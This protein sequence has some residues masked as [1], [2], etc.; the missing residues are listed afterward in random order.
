[1]QSDTLAYGFA[2]SQ[3]IL[4]R[5]LAGISHEES[6]VST[7]DCAN[8]INWLAGHI[9]A[10]RGRLAT[11][12]QAGEPLLSP[13]QAAAYARGSGPIRPG[14]P[15]VPLEKLI[16]AL[17]GSGAELVER[18]KAMTDE[19]LETA[20]DPS[21]FPIRPDT[22]TVGASIAF[23]LLHEGYH[24]GQIGLASRLIGKPSGL[25]V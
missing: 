6:L 19:D 2:A 8:C 5:N 17:E 18:I 20:L 3:K 14:D 10:T 24:A 23:V 9:L 22:P 25:G 15:C 4:D 1:M 21:R 11:L 12:I 16:A 13:G 7:H